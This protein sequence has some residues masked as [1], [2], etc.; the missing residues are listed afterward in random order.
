M[1]ALVLRR[2]LE[3]RI[4]PWVM[5]ATGSILVAIFIAAADMAFAQ[6]GQQEQSRYEVLPV[7]AVTIYPGD[8]IA[9]AMLTEAHFLPGTLAMY[10]VADSRA[11]VIGKV[12]RRT[13]MPDRLI[14]MN[15][16]AE[17][18]LVARGSMIA[19]VYQSSG[20]SISANMLALEGG[21][22]GKLIQVRNID[23]GRVVTGIVQADGTVRVGD[24]T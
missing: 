8:V 13:L 12:A 18:E 15:A 10:P 14:S 9:D 3:G 23:S 5:A 11:A 4:Q 6:A 22:L 2:A 1:I 24:G 20:L 7:P 16:I 21:A 19:V 17:P